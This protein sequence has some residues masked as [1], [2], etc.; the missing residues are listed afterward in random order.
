[1]WD[2]RGVEQHRA[3]F[4]RSCEILSTA[5]KVC[6]G[7]LWDVGQGRVQDVGLGFKGWGFKIYVE[8][9]AQQRLPSGE[10]RTTAWSL[11]DGMGSWI[12]RALSLERLRS[13][14][15]SF[16]KFPIQAYG[17][18]KNRCWLQRP[19]WWEIIFVRPVLCLPVP[20][21]TYHTPLSAR[22]LPIQNSI[23]C[24]MKPTTC[25]WLRTLKEPRFP[26]TL[27]PNG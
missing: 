4:R 19:P 13:S 22:S 16:G 24:E 6:I 7:V 11:R 26:S 25:H 23:H 5:S 18:G 3:S 27:V 17:S 15:P 9:V 21:L 1:M 14:A 2:V 12:L 8:N 10:F 20:A